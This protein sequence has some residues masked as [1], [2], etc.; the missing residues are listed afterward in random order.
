MIEPPKISL[1]YN[2][3][4]GF[5]EVDQWAYCCSPV[6]NKACHMAR[7]HDL[8]EADRLRLIATFLLLRM[9]DVENREVERALKAINK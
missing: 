8:S 6:W 4:K 7:Q 5:N 9:L 3:L 2:E 1:D